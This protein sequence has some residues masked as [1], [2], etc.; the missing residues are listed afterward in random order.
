MAKDKYTKMLGKDSR[1]V[2][3]KILDRQAQEIAELKA[4]GHAH[5]EALLENA[6]LIKERDEL[7]AAFDRCCDH[8]ATIA[9]DAQIDT[10][11][12][13]HRVCRLMVSTHKSPFQG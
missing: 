13:M 1:G 8:C 2:D 12:K 10:W 7:K 5:R 9:V 4:N 11:E 6:K 3:L